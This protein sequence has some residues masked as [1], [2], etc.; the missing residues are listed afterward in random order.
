MYFG[1]AMKNASQADIPATKGN[2]TASPVSK[3]QSAIKSLLGKSYD[4]DAET[5]ELQYRG[6]PVSFWIT[7]HEAEMVQQAKTFA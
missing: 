4:W 3:M 6:N 7:D 1:L 2:G 5:N